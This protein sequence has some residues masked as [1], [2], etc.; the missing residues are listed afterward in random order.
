M[1][2]IFLWGML[3]AMILLASC[4]PAEKPSGGIEITQVMVAVGGAQGSVS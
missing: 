2:R 3:F 4:A 1:K